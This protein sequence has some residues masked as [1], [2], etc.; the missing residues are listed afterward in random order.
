MSGRTKTRNSW[1]IAESLA[2]LHE[3]VLR[4]FLTGRVSESA[5]LRR[6]LIRRLRTELEVQHRNT[7]LWCV[8][9]E[10]YSSA[11]KRIA[12]Y[13]EALRTNPRDAEA[14]AEVAELYA[15]CG[16]SRYAR[17]FDRALLYCRGIDIED[18]IIYSA[19]QAARAAQDKRRI[20]RALRLGR[21]R[22]PDCSL[23]Q[24]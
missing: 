12:C 6:V 11:K 22:L 13:R 15:K 20:Q 5:K 16:D 18:S 8:L 17:Y 19:L 14:C 9:G 1:E 21:R 4:L 23:F 2:T 3:E 10:T 24:S 7:R